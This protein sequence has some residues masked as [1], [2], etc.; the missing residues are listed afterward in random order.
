VEVENVWGKP[1][2]KL[3]D[4][5]SMVQDI[6]I[7]HHPPLVEEK[8]DF[9]VMAGICNMTSRLKTNRPHYE[10]IVFTDKDEAVKSTFRE[11]EQLAKAILNEG[12]RPIICTIPSMHLKTWNTIRL[13]QGKTSHLNYVAEYDRMQ[14]DLDESL[15]DLNNLIAKFNSD[16]GVS[17]PFTH[18]SLLR[19]KHGKKYILYKL[20]NDGCHPGDKMTLSIIHSL[21][22]AIKKNRA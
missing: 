15:D 16:A 9:Y 14:K 1:G 20:L 17:T 22:T 3:G 13:S 12:A 6:N 19:N 4:C 8:T 10:E 5:M 21:N 18:T 2:A 7:L 11:I